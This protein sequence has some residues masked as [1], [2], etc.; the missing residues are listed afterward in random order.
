MS[1]IFISSELDEM[2]R[3]CTRMLIMRD[4]KKVGELTSSETELTQG[5]IMNAIAGGE[6]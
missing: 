4:G 1:V 2:I 5:V 3:T 6:K